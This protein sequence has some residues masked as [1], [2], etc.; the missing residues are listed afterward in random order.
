MGKDSENTTIQVLSPQY[1]QFGQIRV[2]KFGEDYIFCAKD[3]C[4]TLDLS[5]V[6]MSVQ[7]LD[8]DEKLIQKV[9]VSGQN[10]DMWFITESGLYKI[11]FI[12]L[13]PKP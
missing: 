4:D 9:F 7:S 8:D 11:I 10:R 13:P 6:S 5:D 3:V 1:P 12:N 2:Q